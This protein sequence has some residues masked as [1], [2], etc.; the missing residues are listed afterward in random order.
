VPPSISRLPTWLTSTVLIAAA[1]GVMNLGTY[2]FTVAAARL[3][4]PREYGAIAALMGLMLVLTVLSL[5]LQATGARRVA[6]APDSL[7][8]T[9]AEVA[10][11]SYRAAAGLGVVTLLA[12]PVVSAL[13]RLDSWTAAAL[14]AVAMVPVTVMGGYAGIFQG[15]RRWG[16]LAAVYLGVGLGRCGCGVLGILWRADAVGAMAGVAVGSCLPALLGW[17]FLR[18]SAP[19]AVDDQPTGTPA[20]RRTQGSVL[21]E[22]SHNAHALLAFFA[23]SNT[24]VLIARVVL[25]EQQAGLYAGG[26]ILAKAVLFLPQFVVVIAFPVMVGGARRWMQAQALGLILLIGALATAGAWAFAP[27]AVLFVG[28]TAYDAL[29]STIWAFA[30]VGTL[31][32]MTQLIVYGSVARQHRGAVV[33]L[34]TGLAALVGGAF[35]VSSTVQLLSMVAAVEATVLVALAGLSW[36]HL[37]A[38][39]V[40]PGVGR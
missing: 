11:A 30:A 24:D 19:A 23:L 12:V 28:G 37:R 7:P 39:A 9:E 26:L 3:L 17:V 5:G 15:E 38:R 32:A 10:R 21:V 35:L 33:V 8:G 34:W 36:R 25:D 40:N 27:A 22:V 2:A 16:P 4:G 1:M 14:L 29:E 13:L 6:A 31:L 20:S 18:T